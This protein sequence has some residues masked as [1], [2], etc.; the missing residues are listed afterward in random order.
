MLSYYLIEEYRRHT[1]I[2]KKYSL[3][4]FPMYMVFFT[5]VGGSFIGDVLKIFP[6]SKFVTLTMISTFLYGLGVGSFEFLGRTRE[7][8][9]LLRV[10]RILPIT[11]RRSYFYVFLRD[12][13]YYTLLFLL[14]TYAGLVV[15]MPFSHL[16]LLQISIFTLSLLVSMFLGYSL[17]YALFPLHNRFEKIYIL[18]L[19]LILIY[20]ILSYLR[21]I[22]FPTAEFQM[23]KQWIWLVASSVLIFIF[24]LIGY[25]FVSEKEAPRRRNYSFS[26]PKYER[27]FGDIM[28]AKDVEDVVRGN[29]IIK[30]SMTYFIPMILLFLFVKIVNMS[31]GK[32]V[33]NALSLS[34]MLSIFSTVVY[35]WLTIM[36][37]PSYL[38]VLPQSSWDL[39]KAHIKTHMLLV[40]SISLPVIMWF[41]FSTPLM[42]L[43]SIALFFVNSIYLLALTAYL[44][45]YRITSMLFD[46][47][48]VLKFS[49]YSIVP[50]M[51]LV[52][53][54]LGSSLLNYIVSLVVSILMVL[55]AILVM[56]RARDRWIYFEG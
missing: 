28:F 53:F 26:L 23:K 20:V 55:F 2:A 50:G 5:A 31:S 15:S 19:L 14:P 6:Y 43:P 44:A 13:V 4:I 16:S 47:E 10:S 37:N 25:L 33:Y 27:I 21:V 36:D 39:I 8:N 18:S 46:P 17:S 9:T 41:N 12:S 3:F 22:P 42:V 45:G 52:I 49:F 11:I 40:S 48:I 51:I 54:T 34:V 1:S 35:S 30:A 7:E 56:K 24:A 29:I 38:S 32:S